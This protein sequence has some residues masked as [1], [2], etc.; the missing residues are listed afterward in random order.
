[1]ALII[2][3]TAL[4]TTLKYLTGGTTTTEGLELKLYSNS[5][6][7][8]VTDTISTYTEVTVANGYA[9]ITLTPSSWTISNGVASYPQQTW[10]FTSASGTVYGYFLVGT[11]SGNLYFAELFPNAPYTISNN[12]D[13]IS[14]TI[15]INL[16]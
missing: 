1:M 16:A 12:G 9:P 8:S 3:N 13:A 5:V 15:N 11:T 14:V 7:P 10:T 4:Q 6:T 2:T